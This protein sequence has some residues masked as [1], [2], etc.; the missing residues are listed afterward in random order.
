MIRKL[1][2]QLKNDPPKAGVDELQ[3]IYDE[4]EEQQQKIAEE[5]TKIKEEH[6][7]GSRLTK[8]RFTI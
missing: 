2:K 4:I 5:R 7:D 3:Q 6:R 8:H 1:L